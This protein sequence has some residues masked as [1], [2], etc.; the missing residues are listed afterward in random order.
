MRNRVEVSPRRILVQTHGQVAVGAGAVQEDLV[1][2]G[3]GHGPQCQALLLLVVGIAQDE[4]AVEV[5]IPVAGDAVQVA[6]GHEGGLGQQIAPALLHVLHPA[7]QQLDDAGALGQQ[8]GQALAD[9]VH[10]GEILQ[11]AAQLVVVAALGLGLGLQPGGQ[12]LLVRE[13]DAV[14]AL[15]H[16][17]VGVAAPVGA[18]ALGQLEGVGLDAAGGVQMGAG[19]QVG[20]LALGVEGDGLALRQVLDELHLVGLVLLL[21]IGDGLGSRL[22]AADDGQALLADLLHLGLDGAQVLRGEAEVRVE[23]VVPALVDGGADGQLHLGIQALDGL[24]HHMGAG[25]PVGLAVG[26]VFKGVQIFFGHKI[27]S[28]SD[29]GQIKNPPLM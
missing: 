14:D 18:A 11:L 6:L 12:L 26:F 15:E 19:A 9:D 20:E 3:A 21:H 10:G 27:A 28:F 5:V 29:T 17:A 4:H 22:L 25:V 7:L 23:V 16:L 13:G 24:G 8:D 1:L 2:E